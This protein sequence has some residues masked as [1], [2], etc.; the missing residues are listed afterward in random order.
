MKKAL[1][2][3]GVD[4]AFFW[5]IV[6]KGFGFI[7][8]P[9]NIF[10]ILKFL[11]LEQQGFWYTFTNLS[12]LTIL[13]D[14]GFASIITQ[15]VSHEVANLKIDNGNISGDQFQIDR[16]YS[17]VHFSFRVYL[18]ITLAAEI[19]LLIGGYIVFYKPENNL[20]FVAWV[21]Y[22]L[23]SSLGL[24]LSLF[25]SI[26]Q[27]L[28]KVKI[29]QQNGLM[30]SIISTII[31]WVCLFF[32]L[33]IWSLVIGSFI[34][35]PLALYFL[36]SENKSFWI[37]IINYRQS[38]SAH[39]F[40]NEVLPLQLKYSISFASSYLIT[41]LYVPTI[42]KS[43]GGTEAA[44]FGMTLAILGV[45]SLVSINWLMTKTP[46]MNMLV[47]QGKF[48]ELNNLFKQSFRNSILFYTLMSIFFLLFVYALQKFDFQ[49][50]NRFL[51]LYKT[52][53][54]LIC[55]LIALIT[56]SFSTYLRAFKKE[57]FVIFNLF[58]A[59]ITVFLLYYFLIG[60]NDII[61]FV[62]YM[63]ILNLLILLPTGLFI[64]L[65]YKKRYTINIY[66]DE[67]YSFQDYK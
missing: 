26:Y 20:I 43:I 12:A 18:F 3:L 47:A 5:S 16:L 46:K 22:T 4:G 17:L 65:K 31:I 10:I 37:Q 52:L 24:F 66:N 15:F 21:I 38:S 27:G 11:T 60:K 49:Y 53:I 42:Y 19:I 45:I 59:F 39:S 36:Y 35:V 33:N 62:N 30:Y 2:S 58:N 40:F 48:T 14:L 9:L 32:N 28:D 56:T 44:K 13:A 50:K 29:V 41:Y 25:Q 57:P 1:N 67:K 34:G 61:G 64:F 6:N 54:F 51:D 7:K 63:L 8:G 23:I 55:N